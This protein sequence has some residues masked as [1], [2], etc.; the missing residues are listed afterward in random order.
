MLAGL[1]LLGG[2]YAQQQLRRQGNRE[3]LERESWERVLPAT[4]LEVEGS[5]ATDE[6]LDRL[7]SC[8]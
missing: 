8:T 6:L 3:Y 7:W 2:Y 4:M 1:V 5:T